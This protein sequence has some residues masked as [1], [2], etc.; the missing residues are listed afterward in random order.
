MVF[1]V[2]YYEDM[3]CREVDHMLQVLSCCFQGILYELVLGS[4]SYE[5]VPFESV[6]VKVFIAKLISCQ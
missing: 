6:F 1:N 3:L 4:V 5:D 2:V